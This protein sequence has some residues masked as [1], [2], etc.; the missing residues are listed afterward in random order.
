MLVIYGW[1]GSII[2]RLGDSTCSMQI[3]VGD[4]EYIS[5]DMS[6]PEIHIAWR[7]LD[8]ITQDLP[9]TDIDLDNYFIN[10]SSDI[11]CI[12]DYLVKVKE[13]IWKS[14]LSHGYASGSVVGEYHQCYRDQV[15]R[16]NA[17]RKFY[18]LKITN[19]LDLQQP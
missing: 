9:N 7:I 18:A 8:K 16:A 3:M 5:I 6:N 4:Y 1:I 17:N 2:W 10:Y 11:R 12:L 14:A 19:H 13:L 15:S